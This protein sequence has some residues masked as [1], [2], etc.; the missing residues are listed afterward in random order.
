[1]ERF[2][3]EK[4]WKRNT[5]Q[6]S[7]SGAPTTMTDPRSL[8]KTHRNDLVVVYILILLKGAW[9]S[10][11]NN[12]QFAP[13]VKK[14]EEM[15]HCTMRTQYLAYDKKVSKDGYKQGCCTTLELA[16]TSHNMWSNIRSDSTLIS[17]WVAVVEV[18]YNNRWE[19]DIRAINPSL[20]YHSVEMSWFLTWAS[21]FS[22]PSAFFT[23]S[24]WIWSSSRKYLCF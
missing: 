5:H 2:L 16:G 13:V 1:M 22:F 24:R 14:L 11:P 20:A 17:S 3:F 15:H 12:Q 18:I 10:P 4:S 9:I 7:G 8:W 21:P 19:W 23:Y 6:F